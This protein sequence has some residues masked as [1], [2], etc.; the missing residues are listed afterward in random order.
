MAGHIRM[1]YAGALRD[2][3][4]AKPESRNRTLANPMAAKIGTGLG[5]YDDMQNWAGWLMEDWQAGISKK[6]PSAGGSLYSTAET[7]FPNRLLL[8]YAAVQPETTYTNNY[9]LQPGIAHPTGEA[10]VTN[11]GAV[12]KISQK[13]TSY[14][15]YSEYL[16]IYLKNEG[17]QVTIESYA[18]LLGKPNGA[19]ITSVNVTTNDYGNGVGYSPY[20]VQVDPNKT[21]GTEYHV[22][23]Y[24]TSNSDTIHVPVTTGDG[25]AN[26]YFASWSTLNTYSLMVGNVNQAA[27]GGSARGVIFNLTYY[28]ACGVNLCKITGG[29]VSIVHTF[30]NTIT[31][32]LTAGST[33]YIA[34]GNGNAFY[35]MDTSEV[36]TVDPG[37]LQAERFALFNGFVWRSLTHFVYY[38]GDGTLWTEVD[39]A[40]PGE[41]IYSMAGAGDFL[42]VATN[43]NLYY[44]GAG[45]IAF[46]VTPWP[47][48][49]Y[50]PVL[51]GYQGALYA[52]FGESLVK[53]EG[54]TV[55][56]MGLDLGEGL[57]ALRDGYIVAMASS[58]YWL[59]VGVANVAEQGRST[60][61]AWNGQ[62]WHHICTLPGQSSN[63]GSPVT[64]S[65][66]DLCYD[67]YTNTLWASDGANPLRITTPDSANYNAD[68]TVVY[69]PFGWLETDWFFGNLFEIYK[70]CESVYV[71]AELCD[72]NRYIEVYWKDDDSTAWELLGTCTATRTELRW[73]DPATRPNTRQI[74]LGLAL[75][76]R[77][78]NTSPIIRAVRLK[79]MTMVNDRYRWNMPIEVSDNQQMPLGGGINQYNAY[80]QRAHL[81]T[82]IKSVPPFIL[83]DVD[84]VQ[85]EVKVL[86][87]SEGISKWEQIDGAA[88]M[89][90]VYNLTMEQTTTGT[91]TG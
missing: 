55:L 71:S 79:Y 29:A 68:V 59:Y 62:G 45:D 69:R 36:F 18:D 19:A 31:D 84:R 20:L 22:V 32:L 10:T 51:L 78:A 88:N 65:L 34:L 70:D 83:E 76:S 43:Q 24:P 57:P 64:Y 41:T 15:G 37:S 12:K 33:L 81:D 11:S 25:G 21:A 3:V 8:S 44:V 13:V 86:S 26:T 52:A 48:L 73:S 85:Y 42:Y 56:P 17:V 54:G 2:Y 35:T 6:D 27:L 23:I 46:T 77:T 72:S 80:Q 4:L 1:G 58:N 38:T 49:G 82:L 14:G 66:V 60:I 16:I 30:A 91:Y 67:R 63:T 87:A 5:S 61:W 50:Q 47:N 7:R 90:Q 53:Y 28:F 89:T 9:A 75:Y 39:V 74:K 40:F